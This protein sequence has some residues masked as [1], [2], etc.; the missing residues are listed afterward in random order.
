MC[1]RRAVLKNCKPK[2]H[3]CFFSAKKK[4]KV[5]ANDLNHPTSEASKS[6][7]TTIENAISSSICLFT[8]QPSCASNPVSRYQTLASGT[9]RRVDGIAWQV[10]ARL[11]ETRTLP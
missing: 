10:G 9:L 3:Y 4:K 7:D 6:I 2:S 8:L 1:R 11:L 5:R